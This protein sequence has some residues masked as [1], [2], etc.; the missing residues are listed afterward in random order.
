M[1]LTT[2]RIN[3]LKYL[4]PSGEMLENDQNLAIER[5]RKH[6][7]NEHTPGV[8]TG[9]DVLASGSPDLNVHV[10]VGRAIDQDGA[11]IVTTSIVTLD[12]SSYASGGGTA[13]IVAE[14]S[15]S[16]TDPYV[17]PETGASQFAYYQDA[18]SI[19]HQA[20]GA[21]GA[22]IE[23]ARVVV[24]NGATAIDDA[25]DPKNPATDEIDQTNREHSFISTPSTPVAGQVLAFS[26]GASDPSNLWDAHWINGAKVFDPNGGTL[27]S[28][29][30]ALG[31]SAGDV[32]ILP[33]GTYSVG[34]TLTIN[35]A[36]VKIIGS[37][38]AIVQFGASDYIDITSGGDRALLQGFAVEV[39]AASATNP[40]AAIAGSD[41][42]LVDVY[43]TGAYKR[44]NWIEWNAGSDRGRMVRCHIDGDLDNA[45]A[46]GFVQI[47]DVQVHVTDCTFIIPDFVSAHLY[48]SAIV[49][50]NVAAMAVI[51]GCSFSIA[52]QTAQT[53]CCVY[54][55]AGRA[56][57]DGCYF[58]GTASTTNDLSYGVYLGTNCRYGVVVSNCFF[59]DVIRCV[60]TTSN[61]DWCTVEGCTIYYDGDAPSGAA[62]MIFTMVSGNGSVTG[63]TIYFNTTSV[64]T[65]RG[66]HAIGTV[67]DQ[68]AVTGNKIYLN[69]SSGVSTVYGI[70]ECRTCTISGNNVEVRGYSASAI[71]AIWAADDSTITGNV[72]YAVNAH[73][74][75]SPDATGILIVGDRGTCTGNTVRAISSNGIGT[76][77]YV[78]GAPSD[79][80]AIVGNVLKNVDDD[81]SI[82][83][84]AGATLD[85]VTITTNVFRNDG[86]GAGGI[87][88]AGTLGGNDLRR[89]CNI[90]DTTDD[91]AKP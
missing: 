18:P 85:Y 69:A 39:T 9:L 33:P 52:T 22:Q 83:I 26:S 29:L 40:V 55:N 4:Y 45:A 57:V 32:F 43:M 23:L 81:H 67:G 75:G 25:S 89:T 63:N 88:V 8:V 27:V 44:D 2:K 30:S 15:E 60:T 37:R 58:S 48:R 64:C 68:V 31:L 62:P 1:A 7:K 42:S 86:G 65:I 10:Q 36:N 84:A 80:W 35:V 78:T 73:N 20:S 53:A 41:V 59:D 61:T 24:S 71:A 87:T 34:G 51:S 72:C 49:A 90:N 77:I 28:Q 54:V 19:T 56:I 74:A 16:G 21:T 12:L 11:E 46:L 66:I 14:F 91:R 82:Y 50:S 5:R 6:M 13:Y 76:G 47:A 17:V 3:W 70:Y 38:G 79:E